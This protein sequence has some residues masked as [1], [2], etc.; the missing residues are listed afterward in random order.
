MKTILKSSIMKKLLLLLLIVELLASQS[1]FASEPHPLN[2]RAF[3]LR[4]V[5]LLD[6]PFKTVGIGSLR[7][8]TLV[9][10]SVLLD[11]FAR[12]VTAMGLTLVWI[13]LEMA[14]TSDA[15]VLQR[16]SLARS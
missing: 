10:L 6:S 4:D 7:D 2:V 5:R 16:L 1:I 14:L 12:M 9:A 8:V 3:D 11:G 13:R 15:Q